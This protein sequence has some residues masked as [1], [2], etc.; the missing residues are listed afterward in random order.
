MLKFNGNGKF[1]V[2]AFGDLHENVDFAEGGKKRFEDMQALM[3]AALD[4]FKPDLCVFMGD[5]C[6]TRGLG[7][8][9]GN[10]A[11]HLAVEAITKPVR[12]RGIPFASVYGNHEHDHGNEEIMLET[13]K[14]LPGCIMRNDAPGISGSANYSE[15]IMSSDGERTA[16]VL[17]FMDSNNTGPEGVSKYD[18]VK[19]DQIDWYEKKAAEYRAANGGKPVPALLFQHIPVPEEYNLTREA[20]LW[21]RPVA[22]RG[23]GKKEN[24]F[25]VLKKGIKGYLGEGP[26]SPDYNSGQFASWKKTGDIIGAVFGHD[27]MNDFIGEVD[28]IKLMQ[29]KTAGFGCYTDGCRSGVRVITLDENRPK[30]FETKMKHFKEF[31]L[32][33]KSLGPV[34]RTLTDRQSINL[35]IGSRV[36][37]AAAAVT[38]AAIAVYKVGKRHSNTIC[39]KM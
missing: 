15:P 25:Y 12:D 35:T 39:L 29:C 38:G 5:N 22:V 21:E 11:F 19:L 6:S 20:H 34:F 8:P 13:Y 27:H 33:S 24:T 36:A 7:T 17:W 4:E 3:I 1:T 14:A 23:C 31:G 37:A 2:L 16:F 30:E 28:G 26:C 9:E 10:E 32:V 18:W